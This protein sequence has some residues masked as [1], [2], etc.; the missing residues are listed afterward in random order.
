MPGA[1]LLG[2]VSFP[3]TDTWVSSFRDEQPKRCSVSLHEDQF[4]GRPLVIFAFD[5]RIDLLESDL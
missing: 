5:K 3:G 2:Q 4:Q 1:L